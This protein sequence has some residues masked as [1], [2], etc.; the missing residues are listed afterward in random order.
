M[1]KSASSVY[2]EYGYESTFKGGASFPMLFGKE[3]KANGLEFKN[4]QIPLA[5]LYSPELTCFAYGKNEG[6][7]SMEYV[8]AN[9]WFFQSI[10]NSATSVDID[11]GGGGQLYSHTWD[12][13]P[14]LNSAIRDVKSMGL[15]IGYDVATN[16]F[17]RL[18]IGVVCP[19]L[20]M[21]S[22]LNETIKITQELAWGSETVNETFA[23][24]TATRLPGEIGY[25]FVHAS[26]TSPL[27]GSTL[28]TVQ[29][30]ELNMNTNAELVYELGDADA[31]DAYRKILELTGKVTV[32]VKDPTFLQEVYGRAESANDMVITISNGAAGDAE[33]SI[34]ITLTGVSFS[35]HNNSGLA[36]GELVLESM[37]FQARRINV[38]AKNEETAVP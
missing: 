14:S 25:T 26:I 35:I 21:K 36:P 7:L 37:D 6:K 9:P 2:V 8:L 5:N 23:T 38:V 33:R 24:P 11:G 28:A 20:T 1:T 4:N 19:S 34:T 18:P 29:D 13:D 32:T 31:A 15:R 27:T 17:I 16:D 10:L 3:Q 22:S 30:F 12:S